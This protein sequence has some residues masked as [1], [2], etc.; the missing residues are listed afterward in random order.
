MK[1]HRP[2]F[3]LAIALGAGVIA[4]KFLHLPFFIWV[5]LLCGLT[6]WA[7]VGRKAWP[8]YAGMFA[9]GAVL[10]INVDRVAPDSAA[11]LSYD[12]RQDI[13]MTEGIVDSNPQTRAW[14]QGDQVVFDLK[15]KR[16]LTGQGWFSQ[17]GKIQVRLYQNRP[18]HYGQLLRVSGHWHAIYDGNGDRKFSYSQWLQEQGIFW[19]VSVGKNGSLEMLGENKGNWLVARSFKIQQKFN[20]VFEHYLDQQEAGM[21]IAMVLGE[22]TAMPRALQTEF[23]NTGTAHVIAIS[24]MNM[25]IIT[26]IVFFIL[27]LFGLPRTGQLISTALFLFAYGFLTG[28][29]A[30]VARAC[31]MS[32][33]VL[34][35]FAF[36][37]EAEALNLLGLAALVLVLVDPKSLF[38]IGFQLSFAAVL[39]ILVLNKYGQK[40]FGRLPKFLATAMSVSLAAWVGTA[41]FIFYY[42]KMITPISIIANIPVVPL[43]DLT[44]A[45]GLGLGVTGLCC[46]PLADAF[47]G[48]LKIVFNAMVL[49]VHWFNQVPYGHSNFN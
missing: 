25:T 9:L 15:V 6:T 38:N 17:R 8:I 2:S 28:F 22:R 1:T 13:R 40:L 24:G 34:M 43:S 3:I 10:I 47:A 42:F 49:C 41:G 26:T 29:S 4:G 44:I 5:V 31:I 45:L 20:E 19:A 7:I 36:E 21:I 48:C 37:L 18:V 39:A 35:S 32:S 16:I 14:V 27:K 23:I 46:A 30:S 11:L 12:D 33:V